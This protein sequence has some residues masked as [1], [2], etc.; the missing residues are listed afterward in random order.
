MRVGKYNN[1]YY[2]PTSEVYE[3]PYLSVNNNGDMVSDSIVLRRIIQPECINKQLG[4]HPIIYVVDDN[5]FEDY[6]RRNNVKLTIVNLT[7]VIDPL[8]D[9]YIVLK[10]K[11]CGRSVIYDITNKSKDDVN[12][13]LK[14]TPFIRCPAG[15]T[16]S[17]NGKLIEF[18]DVEYKRRKM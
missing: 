4:E 14:E 17:N 15:G 6:C 18:V 3:L 7:N 1:M 13:W 12:K 9:N 2:V 5:L 10:C 11:I 16:H 8:P